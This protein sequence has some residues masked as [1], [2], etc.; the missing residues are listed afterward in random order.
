MAW[1]LS[2]VVALLTGGLGGLARLVRPLA[3]ASLVFIPPNALTALFFACTCR[4]IETDC[5]TTGRQF[6]AE[7]EHVH[8]HSVVHNQG[9][10]QI[11]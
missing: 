4:F 11:T 3:W 6:D 1:V 8:L 2:F 9:A 7:E 5:S 10:D